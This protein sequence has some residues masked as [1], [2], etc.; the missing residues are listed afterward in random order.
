MNVY[1]QLT[2]SLALELHGVLR[3]GRRTVNGRPA[4]P[5]NVNLTTRQNHE[6]D[7]AAERIAGALPHSG[8]DAVVTE[9]ARA[10][11]PMSRSVS[12]AGRGLAELVVL[13]TTMMPEYTKP[14]TQYIEGLAVSSLP[15]LLLRTVQQVQLRCDARDFIDLVAME[16][17]LGPDR[18]DHLTASWLDRQAGTSPD[19]AVRL[20]E[21]LHYGLSRVMTVTAT[22]MASHGLGNREMGE[23]QDRMVQLARRVAEHVPIA[24]GQPTNSL[25]RLLSLSDSELA[26]MRAMAQA[27]GITPSEVE[28]RVASPAEMAKQRFIAERDAVAAA[29]EQRYRGRLA[30]TR[31][32]G[33]M[34]REAAQAHRHGTPDKGAPP[35]TP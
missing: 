14:P 21:V 19:A 25:E 24:E 35:P 20:H 10:D 4:G 33:A 18:V 34:Q 6:P 23:V 8:W 2:G 12:V 15:T 29:A 1:F 30:P 27:L 32:T 22:E 9:E 16:D 28:M 5:L 26:E 3:R 17:A 7:R 31:L 13:T 11:H